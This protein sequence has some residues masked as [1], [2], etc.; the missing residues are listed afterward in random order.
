MYMNICLVW[1]SGRFKDK[2]NGHG[3]QWYATPQH[4][5]VTI[6]LY[7]YF[8][9]HWIVDRIRFQTMWRRI[10]GPVCHDRLPPRH[11][12]VGKVDYPQWYHC[13]PDCVSNPQSKCSD[14]TTTEDRGQPHSHCRGRTRAV[15]VCPTYKLTLGTM[16]KANV[17]ILCVFYMTVCVT[18]YYLS[19]SCMHKSTLL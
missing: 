19:R 15:W 7:S 17:Q 18:E 16:A 12:T 6:S 9:N 2:S 5:F 13:V 3:T 14:L 4:N 10:F 1:C 11:E 8:N